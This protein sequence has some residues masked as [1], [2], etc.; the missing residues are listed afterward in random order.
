MRKI[1]K[2][3]FIHSLNNYTGSPNVLAVAVK[4][5]I[6]RGYVV[7]LHT[8]QTEGFLTGIPGVMYRHTCYRWTSNGAINLLLLF[9]SQFQL[10]FRLIFT[11]RKNTVFYIN[12]I[13]PFGAALACWVSGKNCIYHVHENMQQNKYLYVLLRQVYSLTNKKSVFVSEYLKGTAV[14]CRNGLVVHNALPDNFLNE[15]TLYKTDREQ[16]KNILMVAS[17]RR[18]KGIYE[19][20]RLAEMLPEYSFQLVLSA[21]E[22]E[23]SDFRTSIGDIKNLTVYSMQKNL[24]PFYAEAALL[25]QL[26]HPETWIETFGLTILEAMVYGVPSI[27]PNVGGPTELITNGVNGYQVNPHDLPNIV[28]KI[29]ELMKDRDLYNSFSKHAFEKSKEYSEERMIS[30]IEKYILE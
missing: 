26:S 22:G 17:L 16:K 29:Q 14:N 27:V 2:V 11:S 3:V 25:L 12:T 5:F 1:Q 24:H 28:S 8:S 30:E 9:I 7:E 19:F 18:F 20:V 21:S 23:T 15:A 4:G 13:I 6:A 10:F